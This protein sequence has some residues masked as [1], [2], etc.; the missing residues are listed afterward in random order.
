MGCI[1]WIPGPVV[2]R[3]VAL[4]TLRT[5]GARPIRGCLKKHTKTRKQGSGVGQGRG[6]APGKTKH[7]EHP[8]L[9]TCRSPKY[10]TNFL[11]DQAENPS[12]RLEI[13]KMTKFEN[14]EDIV[15]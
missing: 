6:G 8:G 2:R 14:S 3:W 12:T 1:N 11:I 10:V 15:K 13:V 4:S 5:I 7:L 9:N